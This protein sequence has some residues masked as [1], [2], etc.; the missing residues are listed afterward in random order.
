MNSKVK[1]ITDSRL[2]LVPDNHLN[3]WCSLLKLC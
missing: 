1:Q 2:L 3:E